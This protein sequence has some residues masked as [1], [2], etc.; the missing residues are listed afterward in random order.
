VSGQAD[1]RL[2]I[3]A[4]MT[5]ARCAVV[6]RNS[7]GLDSLAGVGRLVEVSRRCA[8]PASSFKRRHPERSFLKWQWPWLDDDMKDGVKEYPWIQMFQNAREWCD[9]VK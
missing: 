9:G 8:L 5:R 7:L 1:R 3:A 4:Q 6:I 2:A